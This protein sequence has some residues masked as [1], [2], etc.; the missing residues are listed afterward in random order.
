MANKN[1]KS[2][3]NLSQEELSAKAAEISVKIF[4]GRVKQSIGQLEKVSDLWKLRKELARVKT[5]LTAKSS[6]VQS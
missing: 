4:E 5:L 6:G 2:I 3:Q 1:L